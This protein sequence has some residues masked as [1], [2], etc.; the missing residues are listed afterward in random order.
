MNCVQRAKN[1]PEKLSRFYKYITEMVDL[2]SCNA[3][4]LY[5]DDDRSDGSWLGSDKICD[6]APLDKDVVTPPS[7]SCRCGAPLSS[8]A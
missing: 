6:G 1:V 7:L 4:K 8:E 2:I 3:R 5:H